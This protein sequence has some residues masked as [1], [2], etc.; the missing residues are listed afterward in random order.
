MGIVSI[1]LNTKEKKILDYLSKYFSEETSALLKHSLFDLYEDVIDR[2][3][4]DR[5]ETDE[6]KGNIKFV[7]SEDVL[8]SY[9]K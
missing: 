2:E 5:F 4:I 1:R 8:K 3:K 6:K 7:S 9:K